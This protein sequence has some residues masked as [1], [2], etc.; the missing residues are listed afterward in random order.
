[1]E[2]KRI[3]LWSGPRNVST[4]LMYA[5]A[6]REDTVVI[7]E[8]LYGHYLHVSRAPHPGAEE[9][10]NAMETNGEKVVREVILGQYDKP[11]VFMKQMA[12][13]LIGLERDF[14]QYTV[15]VLLIRDPE[16]MLPSLAK[17]IPHPTL[18]DTALAI[19]AELYDELKEMEQSPPV[20]DARELLL[21]PPGVLRE[22]CRRIDIPFQESMLHWQPGARPEDGVWAKYWY[23]NLHKSSGFQPYRKKTDPFPEH[24]RPLLRECQPY[25][26]ALYRHALKA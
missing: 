20:L 12:H 13:H 8:P 17:Q 4:A 21:N 7:D 26:R 6:Q 24:L 18:T 22:L 14:L 10:L 25:Y 2:I 1:M 23:H 5:F 9:V 15:N 16:E 11:V 3:C 19:Q